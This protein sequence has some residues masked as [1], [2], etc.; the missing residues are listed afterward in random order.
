M[1]EMRLGKVVIVGGGSAGWMAAAAL[2]NLIGRLAAEVVLIES[3]RLGTIGVGEATLPTLRFFNRTLGIDEVDFIRRTN[4]TFKLGIQFCDWSRPGQSFFHGF[5]DF[6]PALEGISAHQLWLA[7]RG[8][9]DTRGYEAFSIAGVAARQGRFAPPLPD[10]NSVLGA[11]SYGFHFDAGLYAAYLRG[12]AE[13]RGVTRI[14]ADIVDVRLRD[15]D[16]FIDAVLLE[17]GRA[18]GGD[19][20]IDCS[21]FSSLLIGKALHSEFDDWSRWLPVNRAWAVPCERTE[22]TPPYTRST[23]RDAGWQ[24]RIPL[25]NRIGNGHVF[26]DAFTTETEAADVLL[27][28]LDGPA[29][30]DPRLIRF[31]TGHRRD[32]WRK[33]CVALGLASG[34][35]EPLESTSIYL[36][37]IGIGRLVEFFP[38]RDFEPALARE[39]NRLM[40]RSFESIRDF[41]LLHYHASQREGAFWDHVR[42]VDLPDRLR[43]QIDLFKASG[44]VAIHD[45]AAF[46]EPSWVSIF[47]GQ[48]VLP[49]RY[50]PLADCLDHEKLRRELDRRRALVDGAAR[51]LPLHDQFLARAL[52]PPPFGR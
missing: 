48:G 33:N 27:G 49:R 47:L 24:W 50:D 17:D 1:N 11:Y 23:A 39:Y 37:E 6:G 40:S 43:H 10:Q 30:A 14:D 3:S 15:R 44:R 29:S 51:S 32:M 13:Q 31:T 19:L 2:S 28:N 34:F 21:G 46:A 41:I 38:D 45:N 7:T 9:T 35:V 12:V 25:R 22:T 26:C 36:V 52:N 4:A 42:A 20:F 16:G 5:G 8:E 18:I